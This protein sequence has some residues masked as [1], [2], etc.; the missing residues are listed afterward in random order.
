ML[1][2]STNMHR[3]N[4]NGGLKNKQYKSNLSLKPKEKIRRSKLKKH[5]RKIGVTTLCL[6]LMFSFLSGFLLSIHTAWA[7]SER[8]VAP[9]T[10]TT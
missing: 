9:A 7:A 10:E 4:R 8:Q 1:R 3:T 2:E 5:L 6:F